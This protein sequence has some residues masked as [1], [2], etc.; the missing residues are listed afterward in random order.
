MIIYFV[1][2]VSIKESSHIP[3][4]VCGLS[5]RQNIT[6]L[7]TQSIFQRNVCSNF[8]GT[9]IQVMWL[10]FCQVV[11][12]YHTENASQSWRSAV[13]QLDYIRRNTSIFLFQL[14]FPKT[15]LVMIAAG[16]WKR[17]TQIVNGRADFTNI[18]QKVCTNLELLTKMYAV[19]PH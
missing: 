16:F 1:Q 10:A 7:H 17:V 4:S 13:E 12:V 3:V 18:G 14:C 11:C 6:S 9:H 8:R 2:P 19:F 15:F 5:V